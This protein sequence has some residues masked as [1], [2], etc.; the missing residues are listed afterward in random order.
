MP[1]TPWSPIPRMPSESVATSRSTSSAPR[2][3]LRSASLDVLGVVDRQVHPPRAAELVGELL[4]RQ[5][6]GRG[7]DDRQHLLDVL[8]RAACRTAPRCGCAG[9]SGTPTSPGRWPAGSTGRRS[10]AAGP[11]SVLT[12]DGSSPVSPSSRRS[13]ERERRALVDHRGGQHRQPARRDA[14]GVGAV[15]GPDQLVGSLEHV[16]A[17][18]RRGGTAA[19][20]SPSILAATG[21]Y[22]TPR[23]A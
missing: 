12:P 22:P 8:G 2:P 16:H 3:V 21:P 9:W 13:R 6:D 11:S 20:A 5:P 15:V 10:A 4:D 17:P 14:R 18:L 1:P 23:V 19:A 7:V